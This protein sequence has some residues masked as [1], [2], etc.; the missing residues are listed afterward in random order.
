MSCYKQRYL[1][2]ALHHQHHQAL[3]L[4][5]RVG[6]LQLPEGEWRSVL[7]LQELHNDWGALQGSPGIL[8]GPLHEAPQ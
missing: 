7:P 5:H 8:R 2:A 1:Q 4:C 6:M 3:P